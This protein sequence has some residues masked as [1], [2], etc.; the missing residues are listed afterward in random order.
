MLRFLSIFLLLL[1]FVGAQKFSALANTSDIFLNFETN[2]S[3]T[4]PIY[5]DEGNALA[6]QNTPHLFEFQK[7]SA[8]EAYC[9]S[10]KLGDYSWVL[11][12]S[13]ELKS[14]PM[15]SNIRFGH[16]KSYMAHDR[17][18]WDNTMIYLYDAKLKKKRS[19]LHD[20]Q[21]LFVRCVSRLEE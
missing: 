11:P 4:L 3:D 1:S 7:Q 10:L 19:F 18:V 5:I 6:W 13:D 16:D 8:A 12:S 21:K 9:K 2:K 20:S 15:H 17:P 14:L